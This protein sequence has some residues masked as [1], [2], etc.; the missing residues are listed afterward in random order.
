MNP[1]PEIINYKKHENILD[2]IDRDLFMI[3]IISFINV[4]LVVLL[5]FST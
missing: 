1:I 3:K 4:L 2:R 5:L